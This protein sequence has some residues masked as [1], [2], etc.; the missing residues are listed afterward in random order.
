MGDVTA[1]ATW[2]PSAPEAKRPPRISA[3]TTAW[4]Y[5]RDAGTSDAVRSVRHAES[6]CVS[7]RGMAPNSPGSSPTAGNPGRVR[8]SSNV[9][10][11]VPRF[12]CASARLPDA[13][14]CSTLTA[15]VL[16]PIRNCVRAPS[17]RGRS[18]SVS[19]NV[20]SPASP[21]ATSARSPTSAMDR[22]VPGNGTAPLD[23]GAVRWDTSNTSSE[24]PPSPTTSTKGS[25]GALATT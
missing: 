2:G 12:T 10:M 22:P 20:S 16:P 21:A 8:S 15:A 5:G 4:R 7:R 25:I 6:A 14:T 18:G 19:E 13:V 9:L 3:G 17:S 1:T 11:A 24:G 23:R